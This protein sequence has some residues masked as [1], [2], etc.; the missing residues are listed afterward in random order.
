MWSF[1][2]M[3]ADCAAW[4]CR[5]EGQQLPQTYVW[6]V[7]HHFAHE[8]WLSVTTEFDGATDHLPAIEEFRQGL[9]TLEA[10]MRAGEARAV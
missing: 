7:T 1:E 9:H 4:G 10:Q 3:Q 6:R 5:L 8:G 2:R